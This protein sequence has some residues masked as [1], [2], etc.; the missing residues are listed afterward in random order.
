MSAGSVSFAAPLT[1]SPDDSL[2]L[3]TQTRGKPLAEGLTSIETNVF[4]VTYK[5]VIA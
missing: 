1:P 5:R 2:S 3:N 4:L